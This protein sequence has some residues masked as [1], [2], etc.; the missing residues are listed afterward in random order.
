MRIGLDHTVAQAT[1]Q[2][3]VTDKTYFRR[4]KSHGG[5][6]VDQAR[7]PAMESFDALRLH[8][9]GRVGKR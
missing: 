8:S 2:I 9:I 7:G 1:K 3:G 5:L 4:R 6:R